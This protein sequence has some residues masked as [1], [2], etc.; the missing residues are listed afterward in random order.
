MG[1]EIPEEE[2]DEA[3]GDNLEETEK[4]LEGSEDLKD[5]GKELE[6]ATEGIVPSIRES[7]QYAAE[8]VSSAAQYFRNNTE[9]QSEAND[10]IQKTQNHVEE[11]TDN[12]D[13]TKRN[14]GKWFLLGGTTIAAGATIGGGIGAYLSHGDSEE[15][16]SPKDNGAGNPGTP[17]DQ[18]EE[19]L[20]EDCDLTEEQ[21]EGLEEWAYENG[22]D[23]LDE[24]DYEIHSR[25]GEFRLSFSYKGEEG[26][27]DNISGCGV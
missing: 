9:A 19:P 15:P 14:I 8:V 16:D 6:E 27:I 2:Y 4:L 21:M 22:A 7:R 11:G 26:S 13:E 23:S 17:Q 1:D 18:P 10:N 25:N 24:L 5:C 20:Y 12:I 3:M